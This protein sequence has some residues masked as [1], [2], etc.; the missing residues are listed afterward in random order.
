MKK[1]KIFM[2]TLLLVCASACE[3][4]FSNQTFYDVSKDNTKITNAAYLENNSDQFSEWIKLLKYANYFNALNDSKTT[5]TLFAP[6]NE[7][8]QAFYKYKGVSR[9]EDLDYEYARQVVR[10]HIMMGS[11][12]ENEF[13]QYV[14]EGSTESV[15]LFGSSLSLGYG[16]TNKDVDDAEL[17]NVTP[18]DT[19]T[20]YIN[21]Q[22]SVLKMANQTANGMVYKLGGVI[23]PLIETV[24]DKIHDYQIYNIFYE[25]LQKTGW[26]NK[27]QVLTDT[28]Y[29]LDG[30][31]SVRDL[32]YTV[33]ATPDSIYKLKNI[34]SFNDLASSLGAASDYTSQDNALYKYVAYHILDGA[35]SKATLTNV[36]HEGD[37]NLFDTFDTYQV[38]SVQMV[39]GTA[40]L[41]DNIKLI[42]TDI[43]ACN[44]L[45]HKIDGIMP[46]FK[47]QRREVIWDFCNTSEIVSIVNNY[48]LNAKSIAN[49]FY[50][51]PGSSDYTIDLSDMQKT[52]NYG[53]AS[54]ITYYSTK[55]NTSPFCFYKCK[56]KSSDNPAEN[57]YGA[58]MNN[59]FEIQVGYNGWIQ[60]QTP[61]ILAGKYRVELYYAGSSKLQSL[62][63]QGSL[64]KFT[65]DDIMHKVYIWK[66]WKSTDVY[67]STVL[68]DEVD[69]TNTEKHSLKALI[70]DSN[71][72][73]N[74]NYMQMWDYIKFIPIED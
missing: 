8:V 74:N 23:H 55:S 54:G 50:A 33:F 36:I 15:T 49:L 4:P 53:I 30:T 20:I 66:G 28:T 13:M 62:Y 48:G 14:D 1:Y 68:F 35:Y 41:N 47:P 71:A 73:T 27:L 6:N 34:N 52:G 32:K 51:N 16:H 39:N 2:W 7:A 11:L 70:M 37:V 57:A 17:V 45:I 26:A 25:A 64:V 3:D 18:E 22:A 38:L 12:S 44:G 56:Y 67:S 31:Y 19:L 63:S 60:I 59:L 21:N 10:V 46:V 5:A 42:R 61:T 24:V 40:L 69:F 29:N 58:Y 9:A 72:G 43:Q 65:L